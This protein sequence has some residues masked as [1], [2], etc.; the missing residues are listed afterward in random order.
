VSKLPNNLIRFRAFLLEAN[1]AQRL[2]WPL[3]MYLLALM[4]LFLLIGL[5]LMLLGGGF[6][7]GLLWL[8][9]SIIFILF[10]Q[11]KYEQYWHRRR[12]R[13]D[14]LEHT[15]AVVLKELVDFSYHYTLNERTHPAVSGELERTAELYFQVKEWLKKPSSK[16]VLGSDFHKEVSISVAKAM[17]E[18]VF[19]VYAAIRP[20]GMQRKQWNK[21][22]ESDPG[23]AEIVNGLAK[24]CGLLNQLKEVIQKADTLGPT[25]TITDQLRA[26]SDAISE[27][28]QISYSNIKALPA[29][30][31]P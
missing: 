21:I 9:G 30:K 22:I 14:P 15:Y 24:I 7:I 26:I 23:A 3:W 10:L 8:I 4:M 25:I 27:M 6:K 20:K 13:R 5:P 2:D 11:W 28:E 17:R 29:P 12:M 18:I 16:N 31:Q 19:Q 1:N